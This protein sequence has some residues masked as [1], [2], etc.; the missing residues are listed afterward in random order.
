VAN[1][2]YNSSADLDTQLPKIFDVASHWNTLLLL[3]EAD[4]YLRRRSGNSQYNALVSVF[5]YKFEYFTGIM[6]L[7]TN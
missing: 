2:S 4:S 6:L 7:T 3:D 5:L 1:L